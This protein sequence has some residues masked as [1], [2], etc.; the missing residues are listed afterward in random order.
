M[1]PRGK[2]SKN[3]FDSSILTSLGNI[4][5]KKLFFV[6]P[7]QEAVEGGACHSLSLC[8]IIPWVC[9]F[10]VKIV[11]ELFI[12]NM[13]YY[14]C[15]VDLIQIFRKVPTL[16]RV[17]YKI[18]GKTWPKN[19]NKSQGFIFREGHS[20]YSTHTYG[21]I[22][23][24]LSEWQAPP[25]TASCVGA[26]KK[27]FLQKNVPKTGQNWTVESLFRIFAPGAQ[28]RVVNKKTLIL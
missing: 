1:S 22:L 17:S 26:T 20:F 15:L 25:S 9:V 23:H 8:N 6:A 24:R 2:N 11:L 18:T 5:C 21:I 14:I 3:Y 13:I 28:K 7:T 19:H 4:F 27:S 16:T 10:A 12:L